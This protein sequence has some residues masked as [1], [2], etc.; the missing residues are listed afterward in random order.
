MTGIDVGFGDVKVVYMEAG[1]LKYFKMPTA[2]KYAGNSSSGI[3]EEGIR[4][5]QGREYLL[6]EQARF[7]AFSTRSYDF[8]RRYT[9]LFVYHALKTLNL[10][11]QNIGVGLPLNWF[12]K[13]EE[14]LKELAQTV[15]DGEKLEIQPKLFPQAVGILMDYRMDIDG[16]TKEDT[17]KDGIVLDIGYNTVDVVCFER[18]AAVRS[19]A[20]TLEKYGISRI[21]VELAEIIYSEFSFQLSEQEAKDVFLEGKLRLYGDVK[22][23]SEIIRSIAH[24]R[25]QM[26]QQTQACGSYASWRRWSSYS[27][28]LYAVIIIK[29]YIRAKTSGIQQCKRLYERVEGRI[30]IMVVMYG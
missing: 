10:D 22:D 4:S 12:S 6:G 18:G 26:G 8:L 23:L 24:L 3:T 21:I 1:E 7:G 11:T 30:V 20:G 16:K 29:N 5:F 13:K 19:D 14:F 2:I 17:A 9:G 15:V 28:W 27:E 25:E